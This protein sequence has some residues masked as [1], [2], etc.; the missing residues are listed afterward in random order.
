MKLN[1]NAN[2]TPK[3]HCDSTHKGQL[4][5]ILLQCESIAACRT[6]QYSRGGVLTQGQNDDCLPDEGA[7][8]LAEIDLN[9]DGPKE[10]GLHQDEPHHRQLAVSILGVVLPGPC[11]QALHPLALDTPVPSLSQTWSH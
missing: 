3:L 10:E 2:K 6:V 8:N 7:L 11:R 5:D 9:A 1:G 4:I